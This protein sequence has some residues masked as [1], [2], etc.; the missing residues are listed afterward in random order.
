MIA[1]QSQAEST[2]TRRFGGTGLGLSIA[3]GLINLMNGD[4]WLE[5]KE[6]VGTKVFFTI[7]NKKTFP[8]VKEEINHSNQDEPFWEGKTFLV[9]EDDESNAELLKEII[10]GTHA[11]VINMYNG[12]DA[13]REFKENPNIDMVLLDIRL[14]DD[15]GLM[16]VPIMK[17]LRSQVPIIAQTAYAS[18][19]DCKRCIDAGCDGYISKPILY[20]ELI[21]II[22]KFFPS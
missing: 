15:N 20:E 18:N 9:V 2:T 22:S 3:K 14:P 21:G 11:N 4:I 7:P 12:K 8:S 19:N 1:V 13:L 6:G 16:M 17:G 5:S 10:L